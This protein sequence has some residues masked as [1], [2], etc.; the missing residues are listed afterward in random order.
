MPDVCEIANPDVCHG[1]KS[2]ASLPD[3]LY[4]RLLDDDPTDAEV[5]MN[6]WDLGIVHAKQKSAYVVNDSH[7]VVQLVFARMD[8]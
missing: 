1:L 7:G 2:D 3:R 6:F 4:R 5:C 8:T